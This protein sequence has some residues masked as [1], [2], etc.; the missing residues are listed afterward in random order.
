MVILLKVYT[1]VCFHP[2]HRKA[3]S[4]HPSNSTKHKYNNNCG[5]VLSK[6]VQREKS[7]PTREELLQTGKD[8]S[9]KYYSQKQTSHPPIQTNRGRYTC[10]F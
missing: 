5:S 10:R 4:N 2:K 3:K 1:N 9:H 7:N 6:S 8:V